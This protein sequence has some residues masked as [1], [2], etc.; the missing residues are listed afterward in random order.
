MWVDLG[1]NGSLLVFGDSSCPAK[2]DVDSINPNIVEDPKLE[3]IQANPDTQTITI[4]HVYAHD[5]SFTVR[6]NASNVV[7]EKA[8]E[9][10]AVVLPFTC[11]NPNVT[12]RGG[13]ILLLYF[14]SITVTGMI[15]SEHCPRE[16]VLYVDPRK[17][18]IFF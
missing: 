7:S 2:I 4:D 10:V 15:S 11:R 12:I 1:D 14:L 6:M 13:N 5:G 9:M 18:G 8:H 16:S 3:H 17:S